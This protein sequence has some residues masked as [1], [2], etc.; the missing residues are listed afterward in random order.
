[1]LSS[2]LNSPRAIQVNI[3]I[4][5]AFVQLRETLSLHKEL[6]HKLADLERKI[7]CHDENIQ[8][9]FEA[10][11]QLMTPQAEPLPAQKENEMGFHIREEGAPYRA[12]KR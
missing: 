8:T 2:V 6:A 9:L 10:I 1:M 5:Q 7:E 11:R 3:A 4:M 12:G